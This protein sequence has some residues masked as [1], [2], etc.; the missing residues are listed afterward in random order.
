MIRKFKVL[1]FA[2][3]AMSAVAASASQAAEFHS[4]VD[5][6]FLSGEQAETF[7]FTTGSGFGTITC[8]VASFTGRTTE[9]ATTELTI[10][11]VLAGCADVLGR[12][13]DTTIHGTYTF[14]SGGTVDLVGGSITLAVTNGLE[15]VKCTII[16]AEQEGINGI[17]YS[18]SGATDIEVV[19]NSSNIKTTTSGGLLN[20]G[21]SNGE[22][23]SG[24]YTGTV[25]ESGEDE[26]AEIATLRYE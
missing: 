14:H 18:N 17:S 1:A 2:L 16:I 22:H 26:A 15:Q 11:P 21:V 25:V 13:I 10:T 12:K 9:T 23:T 24:T 5:E 6:T 20:C 19:A 7:K 4:S 3:F 8:T